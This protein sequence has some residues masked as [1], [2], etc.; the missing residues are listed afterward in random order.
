[1]NL[2][3]TGKI[4]IL[5]DDLLFLDLCK[6]ILE[7]R[8]FEVFAMAKT[9]DF[10]KRI[11][12]EKPDVVVLDIN[13]PDVSGWEVLGILRSVVKEY[14]PVVLTTIEADKELAAAKG[15]AHYFA[16]PVDIERFVAVM[17][18]YCIGGKKHDV[19]VVEDYHP[20]EIPL[21]EEV[22]NKNWYCFGVYDF[23]AAEL[24]LQK[25]SPKVICVAKD[26]KE[27]EAFKQKAKPSKIIYVENRQDIE[28]LALH[29]G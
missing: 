13:L 24:Y 12:K 14:I 25:N 3:K 1:M 2:N 23:A 29:F 6:S 18:A 8:G 19:L 27:L 21:R 10:L 26:K 20:F 7:A 15:I 5:D 28:N 11:I 9:D 16:K 22:R 17:E 4:F